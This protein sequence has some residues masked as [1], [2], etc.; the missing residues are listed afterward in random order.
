MRNPRGCLKRVFIFTGSLLLVLLL[1]AYGLFQVSRSRSFQLFGD[2]VARVDTPEKVVA[3]TFDDGPTPQFTEEILELLEDEG[4]SATFFLTGRE[5]TQN[6]EQAQRIVRSGHEVGNHSWSHQRMVLKSPAFVEEEITR[7]DQA[8]AAAGYTSATVFRP[9]YG[10]KLFTLPWYLGR[11]GRTSVTWDVEPES[12]PDIAASPEKIAAHVLEKV[13]PGS[14]ILLHVMYDKERK[15][16]RAARLVIDGLR[17]RGYR[18]I[19]VS[20]LL[21][22]SR[23]N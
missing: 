13:R 8:I 11:T 21:N 16:Q 19:T 10:K 1:L 23:L 15:S 4:T 5:I 14:I 7:T 6:P 12:F 22:S 18:F 20:E 3:L 9:P 17:S 2:I